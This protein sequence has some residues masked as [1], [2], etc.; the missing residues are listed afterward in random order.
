MSEN[1][2][3]YVR[4]DCYVSAFTDVEKS[5]RNVVDRQQNS[6]EPQLGSLVRRS[7]EKK[8]GTEWNYIS[9]GLKKRVIE[10]WCSMTSGITTCAGNC[11]VWDTNSFVHM[12]DVLGLCESNWCSWLGAPSP[13]EDTMVVAKNGRGPFEQCPVPKDD[14]CPTY[15]DRKNLSFVKVCKGSILSYKSVLTPRTLPHHHTSALPPCGVSG[16]EHRRCYLHRPS[17]VAE[18]NRS[19]RANR[20]LA[21]HREPSQQLSRACHTPATPPPPYPTVGQ[22][23]QRVTPEPLLVVPARFSFRVL[24]VF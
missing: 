7:L 2:A 16:R 24:S 22:Q 1:V 14:P 12:L 5:I 20:S 10:H 23:H 4:Q 8:C 6:L 15:W 21:T 17:R 3:A 19:T 9:A 18:G 13:A 11:V